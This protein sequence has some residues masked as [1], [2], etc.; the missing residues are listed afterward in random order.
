MRSPPNA[1]RRSYVYSRLKR[2]ILSNLGAG[3][4]TTQIARA[5]CGKDNV[6]EDPACSDVLLLA[7]TPDAYNSNNTADTPGGLALISPAQVS[8]LVSCCL[9]SCP[10]SNL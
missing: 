5:A 7:L 10:I 3:A 6:T 2:G 8:V 1:T 4:N 9:V